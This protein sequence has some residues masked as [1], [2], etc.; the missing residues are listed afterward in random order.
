MKIQEL[1]VSKLKIKPTKQNIDKALGV[2]PPIPNKNSVIFISGGQGTGKSTFISNLFKASGENRIYKKVFDAV[3]YATP[4]E[5]FQSE[6]DHVFKGHPR[7]YHDLSPET[8]ERIND[9]AVQVK[10]DDGDTC[11]VIDDFSEQLK[12]KKTELMLRRLINKHRHLRLNI[13]IS[14]LN[15]KALAKTL[16]S[17]IDVVILF[18][19]KSMVETDSFGEEV[20]GLNRAETKELFDFVFDKQYNFLMY[21][22]RTHTFYKNFNELSIEDEK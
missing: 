17:L 5:V 18:K 7:V 15:Q 12:L 20:F 11:L 16:R 22:A 19:P 3:I 4:E 10:N 2:P 21:N 14:A 1:D 9:I 13:I 6:E 8:F